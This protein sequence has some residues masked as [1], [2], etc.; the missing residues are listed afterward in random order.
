MTKTWLGIY[1]AK[2][3]K[4]YDRVLADKQLDANAVAACER[5]LAICEGSDWFWWFGDYNA[6]DSVESFDRL[7]QIKSHEFISITQSTH[8]TRAQSFD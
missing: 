2:L 4:W 7:Y 1:S 3:K 5:Q 6:S 8:S